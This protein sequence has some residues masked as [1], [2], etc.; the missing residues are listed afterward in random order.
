MSGA[1]H[2][3][4]GPQQTAQYILLQSVQSHLQIFAAEYP[5][6]PWFYPE[7]QANLNHM[8]CLYGL[9]LDAHVFDPEHHL[10]EIL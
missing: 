2:K 7:A 5:P 6:C 3:P 9:A 1:G 8:I 4:G 10:A